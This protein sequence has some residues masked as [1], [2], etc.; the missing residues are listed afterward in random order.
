VIETISHE[1][2]E[3]DLDIRSFQ[4]AAEG[5]AFTATISL[6]VRNTDQLRLATRALQNLDNVSTVS[7]VE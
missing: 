6:L 4:I 5:G 7:R 3:M 1:I 2:T